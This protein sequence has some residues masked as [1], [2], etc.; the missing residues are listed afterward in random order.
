MNKLKLITT[1]SDPQHPGWLQFKRSLDHFGWNYHLIVHEYRGFNS[2]IE[3][4][5]NYLSSIRG[6]IEHFIYADSYDSFVLSTPK[7]V[8]DKLQNWDGITHITE[9]ACWPYEDWAAEYPNS[10]YPHK[11]LN[12]GG[13]IGSV[14]KFIQVYERCPI[15]DSGWDNDQIWQADNFLRKNEDG[16]IKLDWNCSIFQS[17]AFLENN[18]FRIVEFEEDAIMTK[19][20]LNIRT[21]TLPCFF[22]ANGHSKIQWVY[23]LLP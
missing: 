4:F 3:A 7:E 2:K 1:A 23:D 15:W 16:L 12:G 21:K 20:I 17:I 6:Q 19:R 9:R 18:D 5:Y 11:Y 8:E 22:H 14:K 10:P 13:M